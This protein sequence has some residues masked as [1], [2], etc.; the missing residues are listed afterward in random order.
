MKTIGLISGI[1]ILVMIISCT[2]NNTDTKAT[3]SGFTY[4]RPSV[5]YK[6]KIKKGY[7]R[8]SVST[9]KNALKKQVRSKYYYQTRGKY[10]R[11]K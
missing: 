5:D 10:R 1:L 4:V 2:G 11:K 7:V 6:G 9:D 8:K 3:D